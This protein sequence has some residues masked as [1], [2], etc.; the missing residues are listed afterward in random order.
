MSNQVTL[1]FAGDT[2]KLNKAIGDVDKSVKG[3]SSNVGDE[4]KAFSGHFAKMNFAAVGLAEGISNLSDTV[5]DIKG[6][7][8]SGAERADQLSRAQLDVQQATADVAQATQD[9]EQAQ[10]DYSQA[11]LDTKQASEDLRQSQRDVAQAGLDVQQAQLDAESAQVAYNDAVK[12]HG[13]KSI[14]AR[15]A[16]LD[17]KQAQEDSSQAQEDLNQANIDAQQA[18]Q[19]VT[20]AAGDASQALLG[21]HQATLDAKGSQLDLNQAQRDAQPPSELDDWL[22]KMAAFAPLVLAGA[23]AMQLLTGATK[24]Q[25]VWSGIVKVATAV[26]TG[27]QWLLN[28]ALTANPIGLIIVGIAA[29]IAIIILIATKT[30]WFQD[31]WKVVWDFMKA[32]GRWFA[33]PFVDFFKSA[34][35][36]ITDKVGSFVDLFKGIPGKLKSAFSGLF[37]IL[38]WPYRTAFNFI[39]DAWNNTVGKL[40]WTIPDWVPGVGGKEISAPH[41]PHFHSGGVVPGAP[42]SE[43]LAVLQAGETVIPAG[44]RGGSVVELRAAP[45][46]QVAE[47][48]LSLLRPVVRSRYGGDPTVALG[49]A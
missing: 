42:G 2:E 40:H 34:F 48:L 11:L 21:Q 46:D 27:I 13:A 38:T 35:K 41:L 49:G 15:Q 33:G 3:M 24:A 45:G 7:F 25:V 18:Q 10:R 22:A 23:S 6:A 29:L 44:G 32:V 14:E 16:L 17:L 20:Q 30:T 43:M 47:L 4:S 31:I 9:A 5:A 1:T 28:V 8:H 39:S 36:W 37:D 19:D 26:W 12:E